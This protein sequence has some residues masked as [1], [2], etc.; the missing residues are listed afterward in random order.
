MRHSNSLLLDSPVKG[1][2]QQKNSAEPLL[3]PLKSRRSERF[4]PPVAQSL[5]DLGLPA[6]LLEQLIVKFLYFRG[7]MLAGD[8]SRAMGLR[9][10][11]IQPMLDVFKFQ[12]V[13]Q[14]KSSLS[15]G[16]ISS[17]LS[18]TESGRKV[19]RDYIEHNQ[20]VGPVPV[21]VNQYTAAVSAQRMP[22]SWLRPERLAKAYEHMVITA[23]LLDQIGPAVNSGKSFLLYGPPG[24]GKTHILEALAR[25]QTTEIYIPYA[26]EFQ[27]NIVQM[28]DPIYH[29][30]IQT[31]SPDE[32]AC[33]SDGRWIRCRRP[34]I[35]SGGELSVSMLDLSYNPS[36]GIYDA[37]L[38]LKANNGIY[39]ID[40]FG[41]QMA[42]P[43]EILNRWIV[44]M[45]RRIDYLSLSKGGK[46]TVPFETF[47]IFSTN[48]N[49]SELGDEAFLRRIQYKML[50]ASPDEDEFCAIFRGY[51]ESRGVS[52]PPQLIAGFIDK[53]Y[54]KTGK[55]FRRCHPRDLV[56]QAIDYI[57]FRGLPFELTEELLD[58]AFD[59]CFLSATY[60][61]AV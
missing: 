12:Q 35:A 60:N 21:P 61:D 20:Y 9:F 17:L 26:L 42:S 25:I 49:P 6:S 24:N 38:Q 56:T 53:R 4:A 3:H 19:A 48:L 45:E 36:S 18:L 11:L 39:L 41:R 58:R 23:D 37:P 44:P 55:P 1:E 50:L 7:D 47:L 15:V 8:L 43:S 5:A 32:S 16:A 51:C 34:F 31:P 33:D 57:H 14:V 22:P 13:I 46:M 52:A 29:H 10:S 40:D 30:P 27:G 59:G 28:L 54:K 2:F